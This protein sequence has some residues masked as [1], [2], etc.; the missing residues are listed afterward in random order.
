[1]DIPHSRRV[2]VICRNALSRIDCNLRRC[3]YGT[4]ICGDV[5]TLS[6]TAKPNSSARFVL[7]FDSGVEIVIKM[8][9][10]VEAAQ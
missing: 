6:H 2:H 9:A 1:M 10:I 5:G 8:M 7:G 4:T 3:Y